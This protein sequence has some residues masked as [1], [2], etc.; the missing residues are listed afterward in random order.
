MTYTHTYHSRKNVGQKPGHC[1]MRKNIL[2]TVKYTCTII[3]KKACLSH[4]EYPDTILEE[5]R[6]VCQIPYT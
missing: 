6:Y 5:S 1:P 3:L 2:S 4:V